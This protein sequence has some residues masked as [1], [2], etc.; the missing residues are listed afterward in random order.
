MEF[1]ALTYGILQEPSYS[2]Q[3]PGNNFLQMPRYLGDLELRPDLR[4]NLD[5][6]ELMAK[7]RMRLEYSAW[8]GA[9]MREHGSKW[10][11]DWYVNEWLARLKVRE[12]L[13]VSYGRENLQWGPSFLFSPSNPFFPGQWPSQPLSRSTGFRFCPSCLDTGELLDTLLHCQY[14]EGPQ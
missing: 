7:P 2:T 12:N 3:N 13:F 6:L 9:G 5:P 1:R 11:D 10:D 4:F 14:R 8:T